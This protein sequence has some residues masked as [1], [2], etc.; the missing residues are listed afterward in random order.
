MSLKQVIK[1]KF[2]SEKPDVEKEPDT[3]PGASG[4][5]PYRNFHE[6]EMCLL[7]EEVLS[8]E[9]MEISQ[10]SSL[11]TDH[12]RSAYET[13]L[14]QLHE[15]LLAVILENQQLSN[16][17]KQLREQKPPDIAKELEK[18]RE[19]NRLLSER[20]H[21]KDTKDREIA[22]S[23]SPR[24][25][26]LVRREKHDRN[27]TVEVEEIP[28]PSEK[29]EWVDIAKEVTE[30]DYQ[31]E[32]PTEP[33]PPTTC[34]GW[35]HSLRMWFHDWVYDFFED[36]TETAV[37]EEDLKE[38][39][40]EGDP[41]T[42]RK[43][44]E[45]ILRFGYATKPIVNAM[46]S[47]TGLLHWNTPGTTLLAFG[48]YIYTVYHGWF[49]PLL[50]FLANCQLLLNYLQHRGWFSTYHV[51]RKNEQEE[52]DKDLGVTD[53]F[54]LVL[55]V[56]RKVQNQS[57]RVADCCEKIK[58]LLLWQEPDSAAQLYCFLLAAFFASCVFPA[59]QLF[60]AAGLYLGV[61]MFLVDYVFYRFPRVQQ[62]YD[63]TWKLWNSLPTDAELEKKHS[64]AKIDRNVI[65]QNAC[66]LSM[67]T[68]ENQSFCELFNL[69]ASESP[70][71]SW[72][73]GRR[74]TLINRDKSLTSAFKNGRLYLT[75]SFL[76]FERSRTSNVKN[77]VLPLKNIVKFEKAKPYPWIPGGGMALEVTMEKPE[78]QTYIFG[79][80]LNRDETY[81]SI[82]EAGRRVSLPWALQPTECHNDDNN[83]KKQS[84]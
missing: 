74:C 44:K 1:S 22:G 81:D 65:N 37:E 66:Q 10:D 3:P 31:E 72:H 20:L 56:A 28:S 45:N 24:L 4:G 71:P 84:I 82:L 2:R 32:S 80:I 60:T 50:L 15:Q 58:N 11:L 25:R 8:Q 41:L 62:K 68:T 21:E 54:Q 38:S 78:K 52:G 79:A 61:K 23:R 55:Q 75:N 29:D 59:S 42:V 49:L 47:L 43:L 40:R 19:K 13:Q 53:K 33:I 6:D 67:A 77:L 51:T 12:L 48:V 63:S 26:R 14:N 64:R 35:R 70:L 27:R 39:E 46:E 30:K 69:P 9:E 16:E 5:F 34:T 73:G 57:G 36:F 18:E 17:L 76:C 83:S 7:H